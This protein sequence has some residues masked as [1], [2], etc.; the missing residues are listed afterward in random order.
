MSQK[1]R[2]LTLTITRAEAEDT[3]I[4]TCDVGTAKTMAKV[5]VKGKILYMH[6]IYGVS[7]CLTQLL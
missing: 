6:P 2:V 4:Y 7:F 5:T 3:D 1:E